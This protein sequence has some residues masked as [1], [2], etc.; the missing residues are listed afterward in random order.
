[1]TAIE[2][3]WNKTSKQIKLKAYKSFRRAVDTIIEKKKK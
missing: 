1:M 2:E 3:E